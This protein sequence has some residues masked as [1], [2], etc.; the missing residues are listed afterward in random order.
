MKGLGQRYVQHVNRT[1]RRTGTLFE[2]RFRSSLVEADTYLLACQRYIE[3]NPVRAGMVQAPGDYDWSSYRANAFGA[4]DPVVTVHP[5]FSALGDSDTQRQSAYRA[6]F[7]S[8]GSIHVG[9]TGEEPVQRIEFGENGRRPG[10][11]LVAYDRQTLRVQLDRVGVAEEVPKTKQTAQGADGRAGEYGW[12][13]AL[14]FEAHAVQ[15]RLM[16][17]GAA[18]DVPLQLA[19][20]SDHDALQRAVR[21]VQGH[22][23][24]GALRRLVR[25]GCKLYGAELVDEP[26]K[27]VAVESN[28]GS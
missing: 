8:S 17:V 14:D 5:T 26:G 24:L 7:S 25:I 10:D 18:G 2:G 16:P 9:D 4:P 11:R 6:L 12:S 19:G 28:L 27:G 22:G 21:M 15:Q 13:N 3:L 20:D 23:R 1:Y